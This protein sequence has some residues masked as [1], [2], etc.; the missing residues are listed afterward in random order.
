MI[1]KALHWLS[2]QGVLGINRRNAEYVMRCNPRSAFP[3][4]DD[5]LL[6]K[7][8]AQKHRIPVPHVYHVVRYHGDMEGLEKALRDRRDFVVKPA[9]GIG[10]SG[11]LLLTDRTV[12]GF[13]NQSGEVISWA[14]LTYY[15]SDILSG[16]YSL[17]G[18]EDRAFMETFVH[19]DPIFEDVT[20]KGVPDIRIVVYRGVPVMG[21]VRLPTRYSD[22]KA[23]LH[24]GA[25]GAGI[26]IKSG[27]T[28]TAVHGSQVVTHHPDTGSLVGG[29]QV[30]HW[31]RMLEIAAQSLEMTGLGFLG[32]DLVIDWQ[33][34][35]FLLELNSR[36]G[37][38]IQVAN[39]KG[40]RER[41]ELIDR[42]PGDIFITPESRVNW[43]RE[44]FAV[45]EARSTGA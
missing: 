29:I 11:V 27:M 1:F 37:L 31:E 25:I 12:D 4:V 41:L 17:G 18:L 45:S 16:I 9:R 2:E 38:Q 39:R 33:Q 22:G 13:V 28:L 34:G 6:T 32:V 21:M 36:P 15:V 23:N 40:L 24:R 7:D 19:P 26:D 42:A 30:P 20:F 3:L 43:A 14:E 10:G 35:P 5:K 8:L 44:V